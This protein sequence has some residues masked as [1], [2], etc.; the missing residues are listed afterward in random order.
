MQSALARVEGLIFFRSISRNVSIRC[1]WI[2][3]AY[4]SM[5]LA[6]AG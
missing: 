6:M 3:R 1:S 2:E 4:V 5:K